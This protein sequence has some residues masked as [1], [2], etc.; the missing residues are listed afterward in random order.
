MKWKLCVMGV[1][2]VLFVVVSG[3]FP[4]PPVL[5]TSYLD[6]S[7]GFSYTVAEIETWWDTNWSYRKLI[8]LD[9]DMLSLDLMD[10]P[11]LIYRSAD[12]DLAAEAQNDADDIVFIDPTHTTQYAHEIEF[13]NG[14][15]GELVAWVNVSDIFS[16]SDTELY[17]Y[18]GNP[19]C[20]DQQ[21]I[22]QTW[23]ENFIMVQHLN[24][25]P[26]NGVV[27]HLDSTKYNNHGAPQNFAGDPGTTTDATGV[28][29]GADDFDGTDDHI[30]CQTNNIPDVGERMTLE[31][32]VNFSGIPGT[33]NVV[34]LH[35]AASVGVQL[36]FRGGGVSVW[37]YGGDVLLTSSLPS[38]NNWHYLVY[39]Y[40][41]TTHRLYV[42][43]EI[44]DASTDDPQTGAVKEVQINT[45]LWG[46]GFDGKIDE[47][48]I[49]N[50]PRS[51]NWI[52]T[53][54]QMID[55][56]E[57]MSPGFATYGQ[58]EGVLSL[59]GYRKRITINSDKIDGTLSHFP[60]LIFNA[61]DSNL[62]D[63]ALPSGN[64]IVFLPFSEE[65]QTGTWRNTYDFEIERYDSSTGELVAWVRIPEVSDDVDTEFFMY[66][67]CSITNFNKENQSGVWQSNFT[68]VHHFEEESG[69]LYDSTSNDYDGTNNGAAYNDSSLIGGGYDFDITGA[70]YINL[71]T[72]EIIANQANYAIELWYKT[73]YTGVLESI[74]TFYGETD[75]V[76]N[77]IV[78]G[79]TDAGA[80]HLW[81]YD[82]SNFNTGTTDYF[83]TNDNQ[84][85]QLYFVKNASNDWQ[86]YVDGYKRSTY[87]T[88]IGNIAGIDD[89]R[90]G[91]ESSSLSEDTFDG[92]LDEIRL[93]DA[94]RNQN[95]I[96][97]TYFN[98][99]DPS[100]F[101]SFGNEKTVNAAPILSN[102][103]P[104][105]G[106]KYIDYNPTL[107]IDITDVNSDLLNV[108]FKT[109]ASGSWQQLSSIE[110]YN[111]TYTDSNA[112]NMN[113]SDTTYY[114]SVNVTDG[115]TWTNQT[116]S[117]T[118]CSCYITHTNLGDGTCQAFFY[119]STSDGYI[120]NAHSNY[121]SARIAGTGT[122]NDDGVSM[123]I[124]QHYSNIGRMY[125]INRAFVF[126]KDTINLPDDATINSGT[127]GLYGTSDLSTT[128][129][130][131]QIQNGQ[132]SYPSDPLAGSDYQLSKY[133]GNGGV[134]H[135]KTFTE[136]DYNDISLSNDGVS[137]VNK[138]GVTKFAL[139][140]QNDINAVDPTGSEYVS[141]QSADAGLL[142]AP[143]L[144]IIYTP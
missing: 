124:G 1:C 22:D 25:T 90:I 125:T 82:G 93:S 65:W 97:A 131:I 78:L 113:S 89:V 106:D 120:Y 61:S 48:R 53:T 116:Y 20:S 108:T 94:S 16:G 101:I 45:D 81:V 72:S 96:N 63:H 42:D 28:A 64:D 140:S 128:E 130:T 18:Y 34:L 107:S 71:G 41:K 80:P 51:I 74:E 49:S 14:T 92:T 114:W 141:I 6:T 134:F 60:V 55:D 70:D 91:M 21:Q 127:L 35:D 31:A 136:L 24:E 105:D 5:T 76:V 38:T 13:F 12:A 56:P 52:N 19:D 69:T 39:T 129:F 40:D 95:W 27:G 7:Q 26:A 15:T 126:F 144:T 109:N 119:S 57:A 111:G 17:L 75:G 77:G 83:G 88:G 137:W 46:E 59:W 10:Y 112:E 54:Y 2:C 73:S 66:Y 36:G 99:N 8:T 50:T 32:W 9:K 37:K 118:T 67:N 86:V 110:G 79:L 102:P 121:N 29:D 143:R 103:D 115:F 58:Q 47:V 4:Q 33:E 132:P 133:R 30:D 87:T 44:T 100:S 139:I 43:G 138:T 117:F 142:G 68:M 85:H 23:D 84:W 62:Q 123:N 3:L 11:A 104:E 122:V 135:S 98:L